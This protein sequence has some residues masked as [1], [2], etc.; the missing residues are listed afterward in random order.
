VRKDVPAPLDAICCK[1]LALRPEERYA[2]ALELAVD[3]EHWL[4]DE[5]V[6]AYREPWSWKL[7]RWGRRHRPVVAAA[8]ALLVTTVVALAV[9]LLVVDQEK[10]RTNR[11]KQRAEREKQRAEGALVA[12]WQARLRTRHALDETASL[13][14]ERLLPRRKENLE[15]AHMEFLRYALGYYREFAEEV[16][17]SQ[18][19]RSGVAKA[20]FWVG[21]IL[22]CLGQYKEAEEAYRRAIADNKRLAN[23]FPHQ[24]VEYRDELANWYTN[25]GML[26]QDARQLK[27]AEGAYN[28]ALAIYKQLAAQLL[29]R[30][31]SWSQVLK[32]LGGAVPHR[33]VPLKV[34][35]KDS[36]YLLYF[37]EI[38][39]LMASSF[40]VRASQVADQLS[41]LDYN[42][43][44]NTYNAACLLAQ[45]V[46]VVEKDAE[47]AEAKRQGLVQSYT[48]R[49]LATLRQA[50]Q[51]GYND[52]AHMKKDTDL[53]PLR[54]NPDFQ[55]ILRDLEA[56]AK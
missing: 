6:T 1:A 27:D 8:G 42:T 29:S 17:V 49:A 52:V 34:G 4:A 35:P 41:S 16:G 7:R 25:L 33:Q 3:I 32:R 48:D 31:E 56:R 50:V 18:Q 38:R 36:L 47:L 2:T 19:D 43:A 51:N 46:C 30:H 15:P 45:C 40:H 14:I 23:D 22:Q 9:G 26:L 12:V 37:R 11:E 39:T 21:R 20:Y 28:D 13:V 53:D 55:K 54:S 24:T 44:A 5:P 10:Q